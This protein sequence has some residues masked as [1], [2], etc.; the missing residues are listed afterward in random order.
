MYIFGGMVP[1]FHTSHG[2]NRFDSSE[3]GRELMTK[4]SEGRRIVPE[5][6]GEKVAR[7][8][9]ELLKQIWKYGIMEWQDGE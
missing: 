4:L 9:R 6:K 1:L 8:E 5:V 3:M 7:R 2:K